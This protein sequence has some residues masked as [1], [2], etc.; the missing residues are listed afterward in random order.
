MTTRRFSQIR[1]GF[2]LKRAANIV[3]LYRFANLSLGLLVLTPLRLRSGTAFDCAQG[4]LFDCAQG[5]PFDYA[6]GPPFDYAQGPPFD[7]A[8]GPP[9]NCAQGPLFDCAQEPS[10]ETQKRKGTDALQRVHRHT[11][12]ERH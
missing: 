10:R 6:Q 2:F 12:A 9:F 1:S 8:Q 5:P 3:R 4:P 7:C 11:T